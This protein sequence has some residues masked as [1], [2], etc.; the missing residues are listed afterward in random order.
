MAAMAT[1]AGK[2]TAYPRVLRDAGRHT[3]AGHGQDT[4]HADQRSGSVTLRRRVL[5]VLVFGCVFFGGLLAFAPA[6]L[7]G[8]ALERASG[9]TLSLAQTQGSAWQGSGVALL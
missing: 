5:L 6:S 2:H 1:Y 8:Y 4:S 9:G 7:M 3:R